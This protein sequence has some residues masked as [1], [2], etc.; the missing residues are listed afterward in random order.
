M[1]YK[2]HIFIHLHDAGISFS[3][4]VL[5]IYNYINCFHFVI[6]VLNLKCSD[7][8]RVNKQ[9]NLQMPSE[10]MDQIYI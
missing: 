8:I 4:I 5:L 2:N 1:C 9:A 6:E 10:S 7:M 3:Y